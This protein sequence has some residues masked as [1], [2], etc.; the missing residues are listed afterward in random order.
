MQI[1]WSMADFFPKLLDEIRSFPR[2]IDEIRYF[3]FNWLTKLEI[4][5]ETD[6]LNSQFSLRSL[7]GISFYS[8]NWLMRFTA[9]DEICGFI[10]ERLTKFA[11]YWQ[12]SRFFLR[13]IVIFFSTDRWDSRFFFPA[14]K[15]RNPHF[16]FSASSWQ[17][18]FFLR[19]TDEI[20]YFFQ[21]P[22]NGIHDFFSTTDWWKSHFPV[23]CHEQLTKFE[24]S[25]IDRSTKFADFCPFS[26]N[27][28]PI[29]EI[30]DFFSWSTDELIFRKSQ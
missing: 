18:S 7:D 15:W 9:I 6:W 30:S 3:F 14:T 13:S 1:S 12:N 2:P 25:F 19:S 21:R 10:F 5:S 27:S 11:T 28:A 20:R 26:R 17:N 8:P 29:E 4:F 16:I 23:F 24:V 22:V